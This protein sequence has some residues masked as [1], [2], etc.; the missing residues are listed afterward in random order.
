MTAMATLRRST[1]C[2]GRLA[3]PCRTDRA[4]APDVVNA[5]CTGVGYLQLPTFSIEEHL[6][7]VDNGLEVR[8]AT[9]NPPPVMA[10]GVQ[11]KIHHD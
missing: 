5:D 11:I 6:V 10:T 4:M 9:T 7:I 3:G 2:T 8:S 1:T